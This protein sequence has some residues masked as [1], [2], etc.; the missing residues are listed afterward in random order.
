MEGEGNRFAVWPL[1]DAKA[2][3]P[4]CDYVIF[5]HGNITYEGKVICTE[6][7]SKSCQKTWL[8]LLM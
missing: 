1:V 6:I 2:T 4:D 3:T 5:Y 8:F 7:Q